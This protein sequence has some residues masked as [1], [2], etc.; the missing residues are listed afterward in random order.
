VTGSVGPKDC[1]GAN[2]VPE[3]STSLLTEYRINAMDSRF[4]L[5]AA[6]NERRFGER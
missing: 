1:A 6:T 3:E 2:A 5:F 4:R